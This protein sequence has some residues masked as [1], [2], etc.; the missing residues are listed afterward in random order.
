MT[1]RPTGSK[2][3]GVI[4]VQRVVTDMTSSTEGPPTEKTTLYCPECGHESPINGDWTIHILVDSTTY[5]CPDCGTTIDS[6]RDRKALI[7]GSD[8]SLRLAAK[9]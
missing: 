6:R 7:A 2:D 8:G 4:P 3:D 5:E 9:N 1:N